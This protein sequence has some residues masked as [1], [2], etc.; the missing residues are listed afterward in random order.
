MNTWYKYH[1]NDNDYADLSI[2]QSVNL[3]FLA[4]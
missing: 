3:D 1:L 2:N 4:A